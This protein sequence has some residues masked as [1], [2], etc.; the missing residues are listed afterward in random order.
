MLRDGHS[1]TVER[2]LLT[3]LLQA[4]HP[5]VYFSALIGDSILTLPTMRALAEMLPAPMTLICPRVAFELCFWEVGARFVDITGAPRMGRAPGAPAGRILD[6][7]TLASQIGPVDLFINAVPWEF[8]SNAFAAQLLQRL[9]PT[10]SIGFSSGDN[11]DIVVPRNAQ[12]TA[13]LTFQLARLFDPA[14]RIETY[15]QPVPLASAMQEN[16]RSL[17]AAH[18]AG[19]KVLVVHAD[20][21]WEKKRWPVTRFIDLLDRFLSRHTE[22]VA[23]IV[24]MGHEELNVGRERDRVFPYLGVPLDLAVGMVSGADLFV[25]VDSCMLHAAD[26]A[27]VPGV[28][29]FG[30][31]ES[32]NWGF[33]FAPHRHI[34]L[35]TMGDITVEEVLGAMEDL[36]QDY[37]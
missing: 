29:L 13:D 26:L 15:A 33:R 28:G 12:H 2:G 4:R 14:V 36:V 34:D 16:I 22:F 35:S 3:H 1:V 17:R 20:T 9:A 27:R 24:G 8:P 10:T 32:T 23:W 31:T 11:C 19:T 25:G 30:P 18:S 6:Y 7:E 5:A 21:N 37:V